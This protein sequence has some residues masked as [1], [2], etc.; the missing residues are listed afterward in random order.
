M[1][2]DPSPRPAPNVLMVTGW[3]PRVASGGVGTMIRTLCDVAHGH[4]GV[5]LVNDWQADQARH[6]DDANLDLYFLRLRC[7]YAPQA[8]IKN[9]A[10][11]LFELPRT[12]LR[13]RRILRRH[14][15][16]LVHLH[17]AA[18][19]Q[20]YFRLC[21]RL[22]GVP[23]V[24][25]VH[26]GDVVGH[27]AEPAP[28]R[29]LTEWTLAGASAVVGVSR[30]LAEEAGRTYGRPGAFGTIYNGLDFSEL[31]ALE[32]GPAPA[33]PISLPERYFLIVANVAHYK[34]QD[35]AI[36]AWGRL[37]KS[38]PDLKLLIVG[39]PRETW[40]LCTR[41][42]EEL[43]CRDRVF[44]LGPQ[45]RR[46]A[47]WL[48]RRAT[49]FVF[50]SRNEGIGYVLLEAGFIGLPVICSAIP[51]F[52]EVVKDG[53]SALVTPV[54]DDA[55]VAEAVSRLAADPALRRRLGASLR[56]HVLA[57]FS[58]EAMRAQYHDMY[59][60]TLG[61]PAPEVRVKEHVAG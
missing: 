11:W 7:P 50:P 52:L 16:D 31:E 21:R 2:N 45:P 41:L 48:M 60:R 36:R 14:A 22:F 19:W 18:P 53:E 12:L 61:M 39:E 37:G 25:T 28:L 10:A 42:I 3:D 43:G 4:R 49:G 15:I 56:R 40:G 32:G 55:A 33:L 8:T 35:V 6:V 34:G 9:F 24:V 26:R 57:N 38:H 59:R 54:E 13:L 47:I 27:P 29:C 58:A 46:T 30:W 20:Y 23:Y 44:L 5:V 1:T 51:P 17:Y